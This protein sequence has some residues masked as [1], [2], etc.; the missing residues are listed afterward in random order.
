MVQAVPTGPQALLLYIS[1]QPRVDP[2]ADHAYL[3]RYFQ[4]APAAAQGQGQGQGGADKEGAGTGES[5]G[6]GDGPSASTPGGCCPATMCCSSGAG[7]C[8]AGRTTARAGLK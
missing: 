1:L 3:R 7:S 5:G 8:S 4:S 2:A 6:A